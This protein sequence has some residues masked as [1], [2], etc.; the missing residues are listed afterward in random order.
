MPDQYKTSDMV[1]LHQGPDGQ[2]EVLLVQRKWNPFAGMWALPGGF[3][4]TGEQHIAA[5]VR[6]LREETG[7][8][9]TATDLTF[10]GRYD[11]PGRDPRG[12]VLTE[13][14][15]VGLQ[16]SP[17]PTAADDARD[18][19]WVPVSSA[20]RQGMAFDHATI[21]THAVNAVGLV[22]A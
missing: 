15:A 22:K 20:L 12:P 13:A 5:A 18:A 11:A 4:E 7:L 14:F 6:E 17:D 8:P 16:H 10:I 21:L 19:R 1:L 9:A 2:T 3:V